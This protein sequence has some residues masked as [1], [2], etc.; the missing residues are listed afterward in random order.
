MCCCMVEK[1]YRSFLGKRYKNVRRRSSS[2]RNNF[3]KSSEIFGKWSEIFGKSS[4]SSFLVY[5]YNKQN[6][7]CPLVDMT[8]ILSCSI[9]YL[10]ISIERSERVRYRV[11]H[12]KIKQREH[13][14]T[15]TKNLLRRKQRNQC[16]I[17]NK[18]PNQS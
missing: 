7:T 17:R 6:I 12:E 8:F 15:S 11:E 5:L 14:P 13:E 4:K 9:R 16:L 10:T 2:R 1:Y 3:G 18:V